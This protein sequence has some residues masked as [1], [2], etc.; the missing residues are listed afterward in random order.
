MTA[1]A[2]TA[3]SLPGTPFTVLHVCLGNICRS[4]MAERLLAARFA[5]RL[6]MTDP[7]TD[8]ADLLRSCSAGTGDWHVG[9]AMNHG[10]V[11]QLTLRG[12]SAADFHARSL[13]QLKLAESD[14]ILTATTS[15]QQHIGYL[16]PEVAART[17][18]LLQFG[19]LARQVAPELPLAATVRHR[20]QA[21]VT[22]VAALAR[23][24]PPGAADDL[25]DPYGCGDE[26]FSQVADD[27]DRALSP[28]VTVL[29]GDGSPVLEGG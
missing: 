12:V 8:P 28:L 24:H 6:A 13:R 5:Q 18:P 14:L 20:G 1:A 29:A 23:Q 15:Q 16:E 4:P 9:Q 26:V 3:P 22:A 7:T 10:T 19:R 11:R 21:L 2:D 25:A 27:V 17:F